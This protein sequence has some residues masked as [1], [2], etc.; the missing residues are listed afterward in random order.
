MIEIQLIE[1]V[2]SSIFDVLKNKISI[3][4][5][6]RAEFD[7]MVNGEHG[8]RIA[9]EVKKQNIDIKSLYHIKSI[10]DKHSDIDIFYLITP[11]NPEPKRLKEFQSLFE[12]QKVSSNW[13]G[14]NDY[15]HEQKLDFEFSEDIRSSL[16]NLQVAS[17][18]S[19]YENYSKNIIGSDLGYN[20]LSKSL[21]ENVKKLNAGEIDKSDIRFSLKRQFPYSTISKLKNDSETISKSLKFGK[22]YDNA[23]IVLSDLKNFSILVSSADPEELNELMGKYYTSARDLV[24]KYGGVLDKFVGDAVLVIFNYPTTAN[25]SFQK[26]IRFSSELILMGEK[27]LSEFHKKLDQKIETGTRIGITSGA[28]YALNIGQ[29]DIEVAF[30][31]DKINFAARLEK[32]CAVNGILL[33]NRFFN[34]LKDVSPELIKKLQLVEDEL[35]QKDAKGQVGDSPTW[36]VESSQLD[37]LLS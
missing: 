23:I 28:I 29:E 30:I 19:N 3:S 32:N 10:L 33:S 4:P 34:K 16:L 18:T 8:E 13:L 9:I 2:L 36:L 20:Q 6:V 1:V 26:A 24:F 15:L 31:G 5:S 7:F 35:D 11:E 14:I 37:I 21:K 27:L 12:S 22:K 25:D 17:I